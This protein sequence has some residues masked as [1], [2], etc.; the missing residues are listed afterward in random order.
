MPPDARKREMLYQHDI[1]VAR[2]RQI[3]VKKARAQ[4]EFEEAAAGRAAG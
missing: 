2:M 3:L 4:I 1:G